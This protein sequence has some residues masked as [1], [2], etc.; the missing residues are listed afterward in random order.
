M[1][2]ASPILARAAFDYRW[3]LD[4]GYSP[5]AALKLVGD[6]RQMTGDERMILFRGVASSAASASRA[7]FIQGEARGR[8]VFVD[9]YNQT[10]TVMHY[11][12]GRP[13]FI[14]SDGLLR[15]AGGSHGRIG[16]A[17]LFA[18]AAGAL[19]DRIALLEP[20][21][22]AVFLD[23]PISGSA[24]HASLFRSLFAA[25]GIEAD[26]RLEDSA[27]A[28][29]KRAPGAVLVATSDSAIADALIA[30]STSHREGARLYDAARGAIELAFGRPELLD[31][32]RLLAEGREAENEA[33]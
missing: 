17:G 9:G 8:S 2:L 3:L 13:L 21:R 11:L 5:R 10:L 29:L 16:D 28:P 12:T 22:I 20:P 4:R 7:A 6:R 1:R 15:D 24:G 31:L 18:R 27:D 19:V 25:K 32:S 14:A 23:A 30:S 26:V 33:L